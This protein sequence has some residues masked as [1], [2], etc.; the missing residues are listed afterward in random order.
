[1]HFLSH[2]E[3]VLSMIDTKMLKSFSFLLEKHI[4]QTKFIFHIY[5]F[6]IQDKHDILYMM[7]DLHLMIQIYI[8]DV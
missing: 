2:E 8:F 4:L 1:M 5:V 7:S 3:N 6:E